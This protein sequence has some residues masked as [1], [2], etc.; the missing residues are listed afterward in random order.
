MT[1]PFFPLL[2]SINGIRMV[3]VQY[4]SL[5]NVTD[6]WWNTSWTRCK[7]MAS[8]LWVTI[9]RLSRVDRQCGHHLLPEA[10]CVFSVFFFKWGENKYYSMHLKPNEPSR[11]PLNAASCVFPFCP[12]SLFCEI[13]AVCKCSRG[14]KKS[15]KCAGE[16]LKT[17]IFWEIRWSGSWLQHSQRI[18]R[19]GLQYAIVRAFP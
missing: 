4:F 16:Y 5:A 19:L 17:K 12:K 9:G 11:Q 10:L 3:M 2:D 14:K 18:E 1:P 13:P 6:C 7:E 15:N 8:Y